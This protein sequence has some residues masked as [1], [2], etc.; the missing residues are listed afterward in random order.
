MGKSKVGK[1]VKFK[2]CQ[3]VEGTSRYEQVEV[4]GLVTKH[5]WRGTGV[6]A[7]PCYLVE[8]DDGTLEVV[9]TCFCRPVENPTKQSP[10]NK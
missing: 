10:N 5:F 9:E 6:F 1:R 2:S 7:S 8:M 3:P 4:E